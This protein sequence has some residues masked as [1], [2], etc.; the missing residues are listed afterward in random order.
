MQK[1]KFN[2]GYCGSE[3]GRHKCAYMREM[4]NFTYCMAYPDSP[5]YNMTVLFKG[6]RVVRC[7]QCIEEFGLNPDW[8]KTEAINGRR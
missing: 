5:S 2:D 7:T 8:Q 3:D 1:P 4:G 6:K